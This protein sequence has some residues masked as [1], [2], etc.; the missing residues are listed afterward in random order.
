MQDPAD[1]QI[2]NRAVRP[3]LYFQARRAR[4][5]ARNARHATHRLDGRIRQA[6]K[7]ELY[8]LLRLKVGG[9]RAANH[10]HVQAGTI[11]LMGQALEHFLP[12]LLLAAR[13][14]DRLEIAPVAPRFP[15]RKRQGA[16]RT[17]LVGAIEAQIVKQHAVQADL[18]R[19]A[20]R[21]LQRPQQTQIDS[22][23]KRF[24]RDRRPGW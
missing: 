11:G 10:F 16:A 21:G 7:S 22:N 5:I 1:L 15:F 8:L 18:D 9:A 6:Q 23:R 4:F 13:G 3:V 17:Q 24:L 19:H 14:Q 12:Q 20:G 2:S